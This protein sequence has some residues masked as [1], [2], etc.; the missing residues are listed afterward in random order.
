MLHRRILG[1]RTA[2]A[3]LYSQWADAVKVVS[4]EIRWSVSAMEKDGE[5]GGRFTTVRHA[6]LFGLV[7]RSHFP[8]QAQ[9]EESE[10]TMRL[11]WDR[12]NI[13]FTICKKESR[14]T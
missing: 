3:L 11:D 4:K 7:G 6:H 1:P 5:S 10:D 12:G 13:M 8:A 2:N 14:I 9:A